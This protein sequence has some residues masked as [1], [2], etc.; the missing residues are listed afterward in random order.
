MGF[1]PRRG[2]SKLYKQWVKYSNLP[3]GAVPQEEGPTETPAGREKSL[4]EVLVS[5][6]KSVQ[7]P[8]VIYILLGV[9]IILL[10]IGLIFLAR[11][12]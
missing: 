1:L 2:P 3:P 10:C 4:K 9:S 7:G 6:V 8:P 12:C 5:R 11:S